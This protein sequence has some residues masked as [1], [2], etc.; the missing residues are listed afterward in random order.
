MKC[1][2]SISLQTS[3]TEKI[4]CFGNRSS[5]AMAR[6][7]LLNN[8]KMIVILSVLVSSQQLVSMDFVF[9]VTL[10]AK[11]GKNET[12]NCSTKYS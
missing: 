10:H 11:R 1:R 5:N 6:N 12:V 7:H 9:G 3:P 2:I 4:N 8:R